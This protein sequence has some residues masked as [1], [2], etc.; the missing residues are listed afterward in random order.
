MKEAGE[1]NGRVLRYRTVYRGGEGEIT[2]KRSRFLAQIRPAQSEEEAAAFLEERRRQ[3]WDATHNC[4]AF[5]LG[6][7]GELTRSSD[8]GEPGGTAGHPMLDVLTGAGLTNVWAV[9]T[10]YFGGTLLG[11]GGLVRAYS[12]AVQEGLRHCVIIEKQ[13]ARCVSLTCDYGD[14]GRLQY[15][16]GKENTAV[17]SAD[18]GAQAV[19]RMLLPVEEKDR[20]LSRVQDAAAGRIRIEE[21]D[22]TYFA[23]CEGEIRLFE[24]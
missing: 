16:T 18:Y 12:S 19:F 9:V 20:F 23:R 7:R 8:D 6:P 14:V 1:Q 24:S 11:T 13:L 3:Y 22:L 15:L 17:L 5:V 21:G 4:S 10:R 2:E